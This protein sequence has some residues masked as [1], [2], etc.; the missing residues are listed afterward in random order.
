M[1]GLKSMV[2]D[3]K[4]K[5]NVKYWPGI[6]QKLKNVKLD[7]F[8]GDMEELSDQDFTKIM[9]ERLLNLEHKKSQYDINILSDLTGIQIKEELSSLTTKKEYKKK[10][11]SM[12]EKCKTQLKYVENESSKCTTKIEKCKEQIESLELSVDY[13]SRHSSVLNFVMEPLKCETSE[14]KG[15]EFSF[16]KPPL[17]HQHSFVQ[18]I[19]NILMQDIKEKQEINITQK[20][21]EHKMNLA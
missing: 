10:R 17:K 19:G 4:K 1:S 9:T 15:K 12:K 21:A 13:C 5:R 7:K 8:F 14:E 3:T 6:P 2:N 20:H 16:E 18:G 11:K